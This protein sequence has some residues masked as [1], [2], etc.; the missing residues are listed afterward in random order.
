MEASKRI[1]AER[2]VGEYVRSGMVVG[3]GTGSTASWVVCEIGGLLS[4]G[5][6]RDVSGIPTSRATAALAREAG[7][8]LVEVDEHVPDIVLDGADEISP[9]LTL[10]KG[11][12]GALLREKIV[13]WAGGGLVIVADDSKLVDELGRDTLPVEVEPFGSG[14]TLRSLRA[15]GCEASP[16]LTDGN[17]TISDG[18]H[19][20]VECDFG[21]IVD[22]ESLAAELQRIPGVIETGL[23]VGLTRAAV[24]ASRTGVNILNG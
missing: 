4:Q 13:A 7:I 3:L 24:V 12:G 23:F 9:D 16:K 21:P 11:H 2:A 1:A 8:P 6:L 20:I 17:L 10:I 19:L 15:L 18:G 22:P 5:E 14:A